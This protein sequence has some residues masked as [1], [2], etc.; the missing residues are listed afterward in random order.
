MT[1]ISRVKWVVI[2]LVACRLAESSEP[3]NMKNI[4]THIRHTAPPI[5]V[6]QYHFLKKILTCI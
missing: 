5:V 4:A 2:N 3:T 6:L 1:S